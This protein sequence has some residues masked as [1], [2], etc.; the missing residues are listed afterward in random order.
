MVM[1]A[2][3]STE[4]I[5]YLQRSFLG[6]QVTGDAGVL[7]RGI[8]NYDDIRL[9]HIQG[10]SRF[11]L[12]S[13]Q[14]ALATRQLMADLFAG[15]H[16]EQI[17]TVFMVLGT[18]NRI[19]I[20]IGSY[21]DNEGWPWPLSRAGVDGDLRTI[22]G[23]LQ[24]AFP[25]IVL[26]ECSS[27][28][29]DDIYTI[30]RN[31]PGFSL[32]TGTP[33]AKLGTEHLGVE[34]IERLIRGMYAQH[35][36]Y[37]V[38]AK[39]YPSRSAGNL[40]N[41]ALNEL[42]EVAN[43]QAAAGASPIADAYAEL[44]KRYLARHALG[45]TTGLW[46]VTAYCFG[47]NPLSYLRVRA[48]SQAVFGGEDS[49]PDPL[50]V[51]DCFGYAREI[52]HL[53]QIV[54]PCQH[55]APG[56][57]AYEHEYASV[58]NSGELSTLAHLPQEEM[59]GYAVR[60]YARFDVSP[61]DLSR[62]TDSRRLQVGEIMD[63]GQRTGNDYT[64]SL[65]RLTEHGLIVGVTGSGKTNT[66]FHLLKDALRQGVPFLVVEPAKA[67]Y[68]QLLDENQHPEVGRALRVFT[69]GDERIS[70]FR[71]NPF[72]VLPGVPVQTHIDH[73]KAVFNASFAMYG[74][75]PHVLEQCIYAIYED[76]GWDMATGQN[77]RGDHAQAYPT[78]TDLY[79]K[80]DGVVGSLGYGP[81]ITPELKAAL[82][83]RVNS[84][85][86]GGKGL[87]LD[88]PISIPIKT[89]LEQPTVLELQ[90]IGDD[91]EKAFVMG[92]IWI[93][94]Y[95]YYRANPRLNDAED[96]AEDEAE[97]QLRHLTIIE[98]AHRLLTDVPVTVNPE[99]ANTRGKAVE[100]FCHMLSEIRAYGEGVLIAEQIPVRL[101]PDAVKNT[102]LKI[103]HR[104]VSD[105]DRLVM[106]GAMNLDEH[107]LRYIATLNKGDA[108][109]YAEGDDRA[110]LVHVPLSKGRKP[111]E[112]AVVISTDVPDIRLLDTEMTDAIRIL[113]TEKDMDITVGSTSEDVEIE[114][115]NESELVAE[116]DNK[117]ESP[118]TTTSAS[119]PDEADS[120]TS[121]PLRVDLEEE[122]ILRVEVPSLSAP[123]ISTTSDEVLS[124]DDQRV[125]EHM[126]AFRGQDGVR[127]VFR[128]PLIACPACTG[129]CVHRALARRIAA[130]PHV[131]EAFAR[132]VLTCAHWASHLRQGLG[133]VRE[134]ILRHIPY[135]RR[136]A[137]LLTLSLRLLADDHFRFLG[138]AYQW[139][140]ADVE[141][142]QSLFLAGLEQI[143]PDQEASRMV[144]GGEIDLSDFQS[145]YR[146][147]C[148]RSFDP[149][150]QCS[151][152][153]SH[154]LCLYRF[155]LVP[156]TRQPWLH[157][158]YMDT[159]TQT[160]A[161]PAGMPKT[162]EALRQTA[163]AAVRRILAD[164]APEVAKQRA[165]ACFLIQ[166][167]YTWPDADEEQRQR[168]AQRGVEAILLTAEGTG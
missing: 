27:T 104:L 117:E 127:E 95:E 123:T 46:R 94:L 161:D 3:F 52:A 139:P 54:L 36:G 132:Y 92:V 150:P 141:R 15:L 6:S 90:A 115:L 26:R 113:E 108:A 48:V 84:L 5:N 33:T 149:Y 8:R 154:G 151:R 40:Y 25:G 79:Y 163:R 143:A 166:K 105:E 152:V 119:M 72:Q 78:L 135:T 51:I 133:E 65:D 13:E 9:L 165:A 118:T 70:P 63:R 12:G 37:I 76:R 32:V 144:A 30:I 2:S 122:P 66:A 100:T 64:V 85:R 99:I 71:L 129:P 87:M 55:P 82:K 128:S 22:E 17:S 4:H 20:F 81:R 136:G 107:Q 23:S 101:A 153:C 41:E 1:R 97:S 75:M 74:P 91:D 11:W 138:D 53:G 121:P 59:P 18:L 157:R 19:N 124:E 57:I 98:E 109:V 131:R 43:A 14:K 24:S 68:R 67:E 10:L 86:V 164:E 56:R 130:E 35:W 167:A 44:V 148:R 77:R 147:L 62:P 126:A 61:P 162:K 28:E 29:W 47:A 111:D 145:L 156:L 21:R 142:L 140:Y 50:R 146:D 112:V 96:R 34:Q 93:F 45:K 125:R 83:V 102:S 73:L 38:I 106:G 134:H 168:A 89:L 137:A 116:P 103:M 7:F 155:H 58:L 39:P 159:F 16:A 69:L 31:A 114:V 80:I 42:R 160:R 120:E 88:T 49:L 60:D 158:R 110:Y